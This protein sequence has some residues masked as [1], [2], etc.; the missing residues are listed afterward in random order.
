MPLTTRPWLNPTHSRPSE[1][2]TRTYSR[3]P[4]LSGS[5]T[6]G[7]PPAL[8]AWWTSH[9]L[10]RNPPSVGVR[11]SHRAPH[12][13]AFRC[14]LSGVAEL[15]SSAV[16]TD[17][18]RS[19]VQVRPTCS[20]PCSCLANQQQPQRSS[21]FPSPPVILCGSLRARAHTPSQSPRESLSLPC[22][23]VSTDKRGSIA[24]NPHQP[25]TKKQCCCPQKTS[26][27]HR[28]WSEVKKARRNSFGTQSVIPAPWLL[29]RSSF[30]VGKLLY[31]NA[32]ALNA[33]EQLRVP[34]P[35]SS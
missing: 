6:Q 8:A 19:L 26:S 34:L 2:A 32:Q 10:S 22:R 28:G 25:L 30:V 14:E 12:C 20:P 18:L 15:S 1:T 33:N 3:F 7:S 27:D 31:S 13:E 5:A 21:G 29:E 17:W 24:P 11:H 4:A 23:Y 35:S 9:S 16:T